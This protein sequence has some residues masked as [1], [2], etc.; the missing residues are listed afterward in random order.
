MFPPVKSL[1][2]RTTQTAPDA[3]SPSRTGVM[4][5]QLLLEASFISSMHQDSICLLLKKA[6]WIWGIQYS[7]HI[8]RSYESSSWDA[9]TYLCQNFAHVSENPGTIHLRLSISYLVITPSPSSDFSDTGEL[10]GSSTQLKATH[11]TTWGGTLWESRDVC[12]HD[13]CVHIY[14]GGE[15]IFKD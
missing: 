13:G 14:K 2:S 4:N 5:L 7:F 9:H 8:G 3:T 15:W 10:H 11:G 6:L 1:S 12:V